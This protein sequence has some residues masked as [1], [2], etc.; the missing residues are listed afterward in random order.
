MSL[1]V[2]RNCDLYL[3][4]RADTRS[5]FSKVNPQIEVDIQS[6]DWLGPI[7]T[8]QRKKSLLRK[9]LSADQ[10]YCCDKPLLCVKLK[11]NV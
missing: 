10:K 2:S 1:H 9:M 7:N 11:L 4:C 6:L 5:I 8:H 3:K